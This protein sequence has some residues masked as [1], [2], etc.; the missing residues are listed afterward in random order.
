MTV[1]LLPLTVLK[2][3]SLRLVIDGETFDLGE[4]CG[5][6][7]VGGPCQILYSGSGIGSDSAIVGISAEIQPAL[8]R[9]LAEAHVVTG[10]ALGFPIVLSSDDLGAVGKFAEAVHRKVDPPK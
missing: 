3:T 5:P 4:S 10:T 6:L 9:R 1:R 8:L 2:D 7:K